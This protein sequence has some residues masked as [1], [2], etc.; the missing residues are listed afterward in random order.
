MQQRAESV[1]SVEALVG[2]VLT[3]K[4]YAFAYPTADLYG[5]KK[6]TSVTFSLRV[7]P[8]GTPEPTKGQR[9]TLSHISSFVGGWRVQRYA[10]TLA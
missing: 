10:G 3:D 7:W 4:G 8:K 5:L 9:V 6:G 1:P 2:G